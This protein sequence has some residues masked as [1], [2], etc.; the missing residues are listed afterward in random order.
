LIL[1]FDASISGL[2]TIGDIIKTPG[3]GTDNRQVEALR[4]KMKCQLQNCGKHFIFNV[5][6]DY[7]KNIP[8]EKQRFTG[9][10]SERHLSIKLTANEMGRFSTQMG[11]PSINVMK[12]TFDDVFST[13]D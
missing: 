9:T 3:F 10:C 13:E 6:E 8:R 2:A 12:T 5:S 1:K 11:E 4:K 7:L